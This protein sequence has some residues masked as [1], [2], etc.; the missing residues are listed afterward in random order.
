M[1]VQFFKCFHKA[2]LRVYRRKFKNSVPSNNASF[3]FSGRLTISVFPPAIIKLFVSSNNVPEFYFI[4]SMADITEINWTSRKE[5][6]P[7][8]T[9]VSNMT[10]HSIQKQNSRRQTIS[11]M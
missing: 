6:R 11:A 10:R 9:P 2:E 5:L 1:F 4:L 3:P 7:H 8:V